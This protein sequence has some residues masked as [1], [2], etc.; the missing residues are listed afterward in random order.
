[1]GACKPL[2]GGGAGGAV[3]AGGEGGP[4]SADKAARRRDTESAAAAKRKAA[5]SLFEPIKFETKNTSKAPGANPKSPP[6]P[7][8]ISRP[9]SAAAAKPLPP[10]TRPLRPRGEGGIGETVQVDCRLT[11]GRPC[12][13]SVR[14]AKI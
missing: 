13:V 14:E 12:L 11:P 1:V 6:A 3:G 5:S 4:G 2:G 7:V 9:A 8:S 10:S